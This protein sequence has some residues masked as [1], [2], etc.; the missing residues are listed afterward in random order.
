[1]QL[2]KTIKKMRRKMYEKEYGK[3]INELLKD[4]NDKDSTEQY[5]YGNMARISYDTRVVMKYANNSSNIL[6][7]GGFPPIFSAILNSYNFAK[8]TVLDP[9]A[10]LFREYFSNKRINYKN[11]DIL[12]SPLKGDREAYDVVCI[13]EVL[14]HL[15]GNILEAIRNIVSYLKP[16]GLLYLTTPNLHSLS[17]LVSLLFFNS[18]LASKPYET[19]CDQYLLK[20]EKGYYGH[21]KEFT[22]REVIDLLEL[23][24]M[25]HIKSYYQADYRLKPLSQIIGKLEILTPKFRLFGKYVFQKQK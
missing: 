7:I 21:I 9:Q 3:I 14:E 16:G 1:M 13:C 25:K 20:E 23:V 11:Y 18:G 6:E 17:G 24:G 10:E 2:K 12:D 5:I 8:I 22:S 15:S 4:Y 19:I